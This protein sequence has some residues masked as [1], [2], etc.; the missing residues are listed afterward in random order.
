[1]IALANAV[2]AHLRGQ[3]STLVA[4]GG[5]L[6]RIIGPAGLSSL[7]AWSLYCPPTK[8]GGL[9]DYHLVFVIE[10]IIMVVIV[11]IGSCTFTLASL[12]KPVD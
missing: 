8:Y 6:G 12:T 2:P 1:M 7:L 5:S 10:S 9:V 11:L 4:V 3:L